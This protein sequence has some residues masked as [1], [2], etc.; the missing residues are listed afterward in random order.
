MLIITRNLH[1]MASLAILT[2][3]LNG[4]AKK[5]SKSPQNQD[6]E[7]SQRTAIIVDK[8]KLKLTK[9]LIKP[10]ELKNEYLSNQIDK[11]IF[12][13]QISTHLLAGNLCLA[14]EGNNTFKAYGI[15]PIE[16]KI[17]SA[18]EYPIGTYHDALIDL[19]K[20]N[21][22]SFEFGILELNNN[23]K[24]KYI[25][26]NLI[27]KNDIFKN[28]LPFLTLLEP[29]A[30]SL[31]LNRGSYVNGDE[32]LSHLAMQA[33]N[34][35]G[36][37]PI[38]NWLEP[39]NNERDYNFQDYVLNYQTS[40]YI[41]IPMVGDVN[42][43]N[44]SEHI[45]WFYVFDEPTE[46]Y[47]PT[48]KRDLQK[49]RAQYPRVKRMVTTSYREKF[50]IDIYCEVA[51]YITDKEVSLLE[52]NNKELWMYISCMSHGCGPARR[53]QNNPMELKPSPYE[54]L[55]GEPDLSIDAASNDI[56]AMYLLAMKYPIKALLYYNSIEQWSLTKYG[57]DPNNDMY[58][59]GG[60]GDGT[61][62]YPDLKNKTFTPSLRLFLIR[63]AQYFYEQVKLNPKRDE[64]LKKF[65]STT[66]WKLS[67][68]DLLKYSF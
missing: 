48:L 2:L 37:Q 15:K 42:L 20:E 46:D 60:N 64:L 49:L 38:K 31:G 36:I 28:S 59:F 52:R 66:Q 16:I 44:T 4:C 57:I 17:S 6:R 63:E 13:N 22:K 23:F 53:Y 32:E 45:P 7:R 35:F 24:N 55:S 10:I 27:K 8:T 65:S 47:M 51:Q 26:V 39:Y 11:S 58:N 40:K 50:D 41:N 30:Y 33:L 12:S 25:E 56:Y 3:I 21:C 61:L 29:Y 5:A 1:Y 9:H 54:Y 67:Y 43:I 19:N 34:E 18:K 62:L 68:N 14:F